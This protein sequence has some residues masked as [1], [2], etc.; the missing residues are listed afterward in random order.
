MQRHARID[1]PTEPN[2]STHPL[3]QMQLLP[4]PIC[5]RTKGWTEPACFA[6][7]FRAKDLSVGSVFVS[8]RH[9]EFN[10]HC[11]RDLKI[12]CGTGRRDSPP[13]CHT[14]HACLENLAEFVC[15]R[16]ATPCILNQWSGTTPSGDGTRALGTDLLPET[17]PPWC[18]ASSTFWES[19]ARWLSSRWRMRSLR[20]PVVGITCSTTRE[21]RPLPTLNT[22]NSRFRHPNRAMAPI[23]PARSIPLSFPSLP[24]LRRRT[25]PLP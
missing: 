4:H 17:N 24:R 5:Q 2:R 15:H 14:A 23:A 21:Q 10:P 9:R 22:P 20:E 1:E 19:S 6:T 12:R 13:P 16:C 11:R 3:L 25:G 18:L 8:A 7:P